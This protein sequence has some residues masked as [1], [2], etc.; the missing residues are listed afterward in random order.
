M[1]MLAAILLLCGASSC[2]SCVANQDNAAGDGKTAVYI[3]KA[4]DYNDSKM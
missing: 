3:P 4:P 1:W 2:I